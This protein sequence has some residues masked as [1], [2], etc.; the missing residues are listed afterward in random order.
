MRVLLLFAMVLAGSSARAD[1][2]SYTRAVVDYTVPVTGS[3]NITV[4]GAQGGSSGTTGGLGAVI[5]GDVSLTAGEV[6]AIAVGGEGF[7]GNLPEPGEPGW[8]YGGGGGGGGTFVYVLGAPQPLIVAGGGGGAG[9][10]SVYGN[11]GQIGTAGQA[12]GGEPY[13]GAGGTAGSGGG[14]GYE[15]S[16][17]SGGG[18]SGNGGNGYGGLGYGSGYGGNGAPSF[19]GGGGY[20]EGG[21]GG[22]GGGGFYGGGGGYSGGGGGSFWEGGGGGGS[23]LDPSFTDT[24]LAATNSLNGYVTVTWVPEPSAFLLLATGLAALA[25]TRKG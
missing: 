3:Y 23:Y 8:T 7:D 10:D 13:S 15:D 25:W 5:S 4:A 1:L 11:S 9:Y 6:L 21:F 24:T 22:G 19:A 14:A 12:G 17:G 16:G 2:F 20:T 18:W